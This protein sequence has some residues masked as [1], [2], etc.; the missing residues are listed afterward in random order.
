VVLVV[1]GVWLK[2]EHPAL[3]AQAHLDKAMLA[4]LLETEA[5]QAHIRALVVAVVPVLL[6]GIFQA[7][8]VAQVAQAFQILLVGHLLLM[9]AVVVVMH[10]AV[11]EVLLALA[12]VELVG[13]VIVESLGMVPQIL[14]VAVVVRVVILVVPVLVQVAQA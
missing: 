8:L 11:L 14:A 9:V 7:L 13:Q 3:P 1:V 4:G 6:V 12:E 10:I 2:T 5:V